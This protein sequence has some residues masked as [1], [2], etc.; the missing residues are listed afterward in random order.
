M[1][2]V[3]RT[4][5]AKA[6][7]ASIAD[8][9]A[10]DNAAAADRWLEKVDETLTLL[11]KYPL[12][13]EQVNHLAL[14]LRRFCFGNYLLFYKPTQDGIELRRVLHGARNIEQMF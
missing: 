9:I 12:I 7:L 10:N 2:R 1:A 3:L 5:V 6:D 11:A 8:Y 13:G 14:G 4:D